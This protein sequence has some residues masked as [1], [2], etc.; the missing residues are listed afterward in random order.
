MSS[1]KKVYEQSTLFDHMKSKKDNKEDIGNHLNEQNTLAMQR[2]LS[3]D[4]EK[5][6]SNHVQFLMERYVWKQDCM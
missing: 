3:S 6:G 4:T 1:Y 2:M 5:C